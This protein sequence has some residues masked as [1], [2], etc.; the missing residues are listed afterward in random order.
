MNWIRKALALLRLV[1]IYGS[2]EP[3]GEFLGNIK[4]S[5][6]RKP[7][8]VIEVPKSRPILFGHFRNA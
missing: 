7:Y 4:T 3:L 8:I 6:S 2:D 1:S 5:F